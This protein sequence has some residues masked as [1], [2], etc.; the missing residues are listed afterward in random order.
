MDVGLGNREAVTA[1]LERARAGDETAWKEIFKVLR[2]YLR[3]VLMRVVKND[4]EADDFAQD[5]I[6]IIYREIRNFRGD[7]KFLTWATCIAVNNA[8]KTRVRGKSHQQA[9]DKHQG[10][11]PGMGE[12]PV[13]PEQRAADREAIAAL[14]QSLSFLTKRDLELVMDLLDDD[15]ENALS[16][17]IRT[18]RHRARAR[19]RALMEGRE[20]S[21]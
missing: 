2:S 7:A 12:H 5:T 4:Q 19:L 16:P 8:V 1:L 21:R 17:A 6:A 11:L 9:L 18:A 3:P 10:E 14:R 15:S 20:E 13:D